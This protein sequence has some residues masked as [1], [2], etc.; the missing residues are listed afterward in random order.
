MPGAD[1]YGGINQALRYQRINPVSL[2]LL[3]RFAYF[4][5]ESAGISEVALIRSTISGIEAWLYLQTSRKI[6]VCIGAG[7]SVSIKTEH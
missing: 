3:T 2:I 7:V 5:A 6:S 4:S 1:G